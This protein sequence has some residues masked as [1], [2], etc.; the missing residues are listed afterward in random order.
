MPINANQI[1]LAVHLHGRAAITILRG[2]LGTA[3]QRSG[4]RGEHSLGAA[5][6][7][8]SVS[9]Q[10]LDWLRRC[11][12]PRAI[13]MHLGVGEGQAAADCQHCCCT[14]TKA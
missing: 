6:T 9:V 3:G 13:E 4:D 14:R 1:D 5:R 7:R 8:D 10:L 2:G 11:A 12:A